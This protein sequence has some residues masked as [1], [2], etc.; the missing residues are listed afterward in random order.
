MYWGCLCL[1]L[2][3][4]WIPG[5]DQCQQQHPLVSCGLPTCHKGVPGVTFHFLM[6]DAL[7][8][9]SLL[10]CLSSDEDTEGF[11]LISSSTEP[12]SQTEDRMK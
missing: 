1:Y 6:K 3:P 10:T 11:P 12:T 2:L 4:L 8:A 5:N 7:E 9:D